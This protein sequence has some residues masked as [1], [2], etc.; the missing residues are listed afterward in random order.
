VTDRAR[1]PGQ[2][3]DRPRGVTSRSPG[4]HGR[5]GKSPGA[6]VC[7]DCGV[8]QHAGKWYWGAP[9]L[10]PIVSG[11]CPA[12]KRVRERYPAGTLRLPKSLPASRADI[13]HLAENVEKGER[14]EHPLERIMGIA[15]VDGRM[16]ITTTGIHLARK[17]A[18]KLAKL[19][20]SKPT[21][22]FAEDEGRMQADWDDPK[23]SK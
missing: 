21:I 15:D 14:S 6:F 2:K 22:H 8:V 19:F 12:C 3:M 5:D 13:V 10:A 17:I 20:H 16:V 9:P 23:L 11:C 4:N 18:H 7:D 1:H